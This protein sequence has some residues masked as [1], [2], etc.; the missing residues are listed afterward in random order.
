M[1]ISGLLLS[2]V[3]FRIFNAYLVQSYHVAD[4][5]YQVIEVAHQTIFGYGF[6][7][8]E[9][10][11]DSSLRNFFYPSIFAALYKIFN[12]IGF[13]S[14]Y[15]SSIVYGPKFLQAIFSA[16]SDFY[17]YKLALKHFDHSSAK[18][19]LILNVTNWFIFHNITRTLSNSMETI[20]FI[21]F[22]YYWPIYN[23]KEK[24]DEK[25]R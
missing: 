14:I 13:D 19:T 12:L 1:K 20:L 17:L 10:Q 21:I 11:I 4:E 22:L 5:Y 3:V 2:L 8:W 7:T 18:W 25:N 15:P 16:I 6:L 23:I 24:N 9:W